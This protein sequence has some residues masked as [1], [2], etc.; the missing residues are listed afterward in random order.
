MH[1]RMWCRDSWKPADESEW[2][3]GLQCLKTLSKLS[4]TLPWVKTSLIKTDFD[5]LCQELPYAYNS[6][7]P[8]EAKEWW[9]NFLL[10]QIR[11][12][13]EDIPP[14]KPWALLGLLRIQD[15]NLEQTDDLECLQALRERIVQACPEQVTIGVQGKQQKGVARVNDYSSVEEGM[16][17]AVHCEQTEGRPHI[18][19]VSMV[20]MDEVEVEWLRGSWTGGW[21]PWTI[22]QNGRKKP[23]SSVVPKK[24][25]ILWDFALT[26]GGRLR[27]DTIS[28]L[29]SK[30]EELDS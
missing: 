17:V 18:G 20:G 27:K 2:P 9:N 30:Y 6:R 13:Y 24:A 7:L 15:Q 11:A 22:E 8:M 10:T 5:R 21:H 4:E 28:E 12:T 23:Y 19:R 3:L 25:L 1:Y 26:Q 29:K 14:A 16:L